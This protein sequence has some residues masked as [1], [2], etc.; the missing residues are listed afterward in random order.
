M[1]LPDPIKILLVEDDED[2]FIIIRDVLSTVRRQ[3]FG[4]DWVKD[5]DEGLQ[6]AEASVH[7]LCIVDYF[8]GERNGIEFIEEYIRLNLEEPIIILTGQGDFNIDMLAMKKGAVDY[9]DK[10]QLDPI[11]L[12]RSIRY[13]VRNSKILNQLKQS[14]KQLH[15]LSLKILD[16]QE[17]ER[18][19]VAR[20]LHDS[21]GSSLTAIRFALEQKIRSMGPSP[22]PASGSISLEQIMNMLRDVIEESQ[23]IAT[24][25]RPSMLDTL[26]LLPSIR[27]LCRRHSEVHHNMDLDV[28]LEIEEDD[29]P[30]KLK[31][32]C[33][34]L[35]QECFNNAA[36]HS[37][38]DRLRLY[39]GR[40][41]DFL[42]LTVNDNGKGFNVKEA[43]SISAKNNRLGLHGMIERV[44]LAGGEI[45][46][47]SGEDR[48]TEIRI[49]L[50][51]NT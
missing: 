42:I 20:E 22:E 13:A 24:D 3:E 25:L 51:L 36:K 6:K 37:G 4:L 9:I 49:R 28:R 29:I 34:R 12:E 38:A 17:Q 8:L 15:H 32:N 47:T 16:T 48:S 7:D 27:S 2:D 11:L 19:T 18:K 30:E 1:K 41:G 44:E 23:R 26:G 14:E 43:L 10:N 40:S 39:M 5:F 35:I 45:E 33:Y 31:I 21:I 50:P 46:I